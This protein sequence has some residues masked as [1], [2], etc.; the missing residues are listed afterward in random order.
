MEK[1]D[2]GDKVFVMIPN[3]AKSVTD[4]KLHISRI[5]GV[6]KSLFSVFVNGFRIP[7]SENVDA[8]ACLSRNSLVQ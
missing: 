1:H 7:E 5:L 8:F 2:L 6:D 3:K 4:V